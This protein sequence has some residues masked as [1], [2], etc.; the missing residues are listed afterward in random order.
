MNIAY[1]CK[2]Q[3]G[4]LIR[5]ISGVSNSARKSPTR[6]CQL[7]Q[8]NNLVLAMQ[9]RNASSPFCETAEVTPLRER[10]DCD[11]HRA[12]SKPT[13]PISFLC[14][15]TPLCQYKWC[16][17]MT[18]HTPPRGEARGGAGVSLLHF[19]ESKLSKGVR[20][21]YVRT[22]TEA[23]FGL[24]IG[25]SDHCCLDANHCPKTCNLGCPWQLGCQRHLNLDRC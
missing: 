2:E 25:Q 18:K 24:R 16:L 15:G 4:I 13:A 7:L 3:C 8:A 19:G 9:H 17:L 14:A 22:A 21:L 23:G 11:T 20:A 12:R 6:C 10:C 1:S 5:L